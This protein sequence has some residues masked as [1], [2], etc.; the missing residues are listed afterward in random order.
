M[1]LFKTCSINIINEYYEMFNLKHMSQLIWEQKFRFLGNFYKN[2]VILWRHIQLKTSYHKIVRLRVIMKLVF[3]YMVIVHAGVHKI[4]CILL[5]LSPL[6]GFYW[7]FTGLLLGFYW[8]FTGLLLG[9]PFGEKVVHMYQNGW[10]YFHILPLHQV[11]IL[12]YTPMLT[13][14]FLLNN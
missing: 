5:S 8:A 7:A 6:L 1:T 13:L 9:C 10:Q 2:F 4:V 3:L 11:H 14:T 12:R